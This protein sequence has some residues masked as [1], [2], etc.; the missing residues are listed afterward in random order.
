MITFRDQHS[1]AK[2]HDEQGTEDRSRK[3]VDRANLRERGIRCNDGAAQPA[4][5]C[6]RLRNAGSLSPLVADPGFL[7]ELIK[8][9][10][11]KRRALGGV[12]IE[13]G[14]SEEQA[15]SL[16]TFQLAGCYAAAMALPAEIDWEPSRRAI[17]HML[18]ARMSSLGEI[19][20]R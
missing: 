15:A 7:P 11:E 5:F 20:V 10:N 9:A 13:A 8:R 1:V 16:D 19:R 12:A 3:F 18:R 4:P 2:G 17:D 14:L 6:V